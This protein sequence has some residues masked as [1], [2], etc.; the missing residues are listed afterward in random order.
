MCV[1]GEFSEQ[2]T[3][4]K[5]VSFSLELIELPFGWGYG[6]SISENFYAEAHSLFKK[7]VE[8]VSFDNVSHFLCRQLVVDDRFDNNEKPR[9]N[10]YFDN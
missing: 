2:T 1:Q 7:G 10:C 9:F 8:L 6:L 5:I 4:K 3:T